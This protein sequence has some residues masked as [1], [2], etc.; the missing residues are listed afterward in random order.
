MQRRPGHDGPNSGPAY[1]AAMEGALRCGTRGKLDGRLARSEMP[2]EL[3]DVRR[4]GIP[5][6]VSTIRKL[7]EP[8]PRLRERTFHEL[9]R[10]SA[11]AQSRTMPICSDSP[12]PAI[13]AV[14]LAHGSPDCAL[15]LHHEHLRY[16]RLLQ[17]KAWFRMSGDVA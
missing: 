14:D 12:Y 8:P 17:R 4:L 5:G 10:D 13:S 6:R 1:H 16:A 3:E 15:V 9:R 7:A 11:G 2:L